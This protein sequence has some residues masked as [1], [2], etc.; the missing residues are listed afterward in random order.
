MTFELFTEHAIKDEVRV[1]LLQLQENPDMYAVS[2]LPKETIKKYAALYGYKVTTRT[3]NYRE[4]KVKIVG[5][6]VL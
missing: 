4:I 1:M 2:T 6:E 3:V 5:K